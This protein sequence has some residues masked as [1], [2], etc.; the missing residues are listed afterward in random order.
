VDSQGGM[1]FRDTAVGKPLVLL[2]KKTL[3]TLGKFGVVQLA[4]SVAL[5]LSV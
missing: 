2:P 5:E 1:G 4:G 3:K